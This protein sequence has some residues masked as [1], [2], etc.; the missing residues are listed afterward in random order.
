[1]L[2]RPDPHFSA[3]CVEMDTV[4]ADQNRRRELARASG[5][6]EFKGEP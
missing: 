1:L 5:Q 4:I 3:A 6:D 2:D